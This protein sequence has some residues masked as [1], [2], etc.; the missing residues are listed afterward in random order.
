MKK[1]L[2]IVIFFIPI[3]VVF[4]L[5]ATS[6]I[7]SMATP[8]NPTGI[9]IKDS[10]N[11]VVERD[12]IITLDLKA[13]NEF[14]MVDILPLM[15]KEDGINEIE[16][17]ENNSG[18]VKFEQIFGTNKYRVI[19]IKIGIAT[20]I[21]S[22]KANVNVR[23][24]VT[25]NIKSESIE[26]ISVYAISH[27]YGINGLEEEKE[28]LEISEDEVVKIKDNTTLYADIYPIDALK[29]SQM[30]WRVVDG[31]SV[32]VS[33]NGYLS[34]QKRGLSQ[35]RVS[36]RD[37]NMNYSVF[38]VIVDTT[39]AI[40][41]S[42]TAYVEEGKASAQWVKDSLVLDPENTEVSLISPL[43]YMV[44]YTNPDTY[45]EMISYVKLTEASKNDWD[46]EDPFE[47]VYTNNG[48]Y[49]LNIKESLSGNRI[50]DIEFF[51]TD[52]SILEVDSSSQV[53]V[54]IKAGNAVIYADYM[55]ERKEMQITVREKVPAFALTYGTEH[56]KLGIQLTRK[57]GNKWLN[58]NNEIINTFEFGLL[59]KRNTFDVIWESSDEEGIEITLDEDSQDVVLNFKDESIGKTITITAFLDVNGRKY[60]YIKSSFTFN[61]MNDPSYVNVEKFEEIMFLNFDEE[62]NI[63]MQKDIFATE[64]VNYNTGVSFYGNGF[65]YNS[66][67]I[68]DEDLNYTFVGAINIFRE[69]YNWSGSGLRVPE[70]KQ[71]QD[72][73]FFEREISFEEIIFLNS[74]T[75]EESSL[76]GAGVFIYNFRADS[77]IS[78]RYVQARNGEYGIAI[79]QGRR[80]LVEGCILG[81][82]STYSLYTEWAN[83]REGDYYEKGLKPMM[84]IRNNVFKHSDGPA[85]CFLYNSDL[86]PEDLKYNYMPEL[87]IEG[88]M[89][90]YNWHSP[91]SFTN[92]FSKIII[93]ALSDHFGMDEQ[94]SGTMRKMLN[95][96]FADYFKVPELS[97]LYYTYNGK[98]YVSVA[99]LAMGA[100]FKPNIEK[101]H[102]ED[103]RLRV[104]QIVMVD[105]DGKPLTP[106]ISGLDMIVKR[107]IN[108]ET[109][110]NPSV[111][112]VYDSV[113]RTPAILPGEPVPQSYELYARLTGVSEDL[114]I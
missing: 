32:R 5:S 47:K 35:V 92:M 60:D 41:K 98:K 82:N 83:E 24:A 19:P 48:P 22:A 14:I 33:P 67:A 63:C 16:F 36:A 26:K 111:F 51:S 6:N 27:S 65:T 61:V 72:R 93:R 12:S 80:V 50:E 110:L 8:D 107:Y 20:V 9:M 99:M 96:A 91:D 38:D 49:F 90:V 66:C 81:D 73:R 108:V 101:V 10:F 77:L 62:Y 23:R 4:A 30:Y 95:S 109:I 31:D 106:F 17:D 28:I 104:D 45:E 53:M 55:G 88:F 100:I 44:T 18:E 42:R 3:I 2:I 70:G 40:I 86:N 76:R 29:E 97:R 11:K 105:P 25:F 102:C 54:P 56:S 46:F 15:T 68:S 75:F 74:P 39:E 58:E 13:Q 37:K 87:Y 34:I 7:L 78:F 52:T 112:V 1:F 84:T 114:Y 57:W 43:L 113:G 94:T 85:V 64:P 89:D 69:P 79:K 59:D 103:P 21:I 71:L